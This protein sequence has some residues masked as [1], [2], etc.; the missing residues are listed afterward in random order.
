MAMHTMSKNNQEKT[1]NPLIWRALNIQNYDAEVKNQIKLSQTPADPKQWQHHNQ[2][3]D[4]KQVQ[5]L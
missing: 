1:L 2:R 4:D 3:P 5:K